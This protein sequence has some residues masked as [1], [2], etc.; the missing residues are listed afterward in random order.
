MGLVTTSAQLDGA[1]QANLVIGSVWESLEL[2]L[3]LFGK[4]DC[5]VRADTP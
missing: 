1:A 4:L 3:Q 5:L 2:K